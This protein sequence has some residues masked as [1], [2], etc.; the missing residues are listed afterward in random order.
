[1]NLKECVFVW[2]S[3]IRIK[4]GRSERQEPGALVT[5]SKAFYLDENF[6]VWKHLESGFKVFVFFFSEIFHMKNLTVIFQQVFITSRI[7]SESSD[8][9]CIFMMMMM[10]MVYIYMGRFL[11][12]VRVHMCVFG[13]F[14]KCTARM[15]NTSSC[16]HII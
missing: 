7:W 4:A 6:Y 12:R 5:K 14:Y 1:M 3:F 16:T 15:H 13:S 9:K 2:I 11:G 8:Y 10:M